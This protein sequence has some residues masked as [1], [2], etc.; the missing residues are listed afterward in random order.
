MSDSLKKFNATDLAAL[1]PRIAL[2]PAAITAIDGC[3]TVPSALAALEN[4]G[5]HLE[6]ARLV[7]HALPKREAVWWACMC[8]V[9]TAPVTLAEVDRKAREAAEIWVR[10]QT[11]PAR[12]AAMAFAQATSFGTP[13]VWAAVAA[14]WSG[15]SMAPEGQPAVPP[16]PHLTGTAV[17]G[18]I[19][20]SAVRGDVSRRSIRLQRFLESGRNIAAGGPG[21]LAAE[22]LA[23]ENA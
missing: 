9:H 17:A 8:A 10:Q 23:G 19:A 21:R 5:F 20:L 14:F 12:R 16:A 2:P 1:L 22:D 15:D 18:A 4:G 6:A 11:E 7:A 13:E 3:G